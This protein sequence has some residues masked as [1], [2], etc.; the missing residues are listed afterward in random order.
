MTRPE[1]PVG[2]VPD[3][4][5]LDELASALLDGTADDADRALAADPAVAAEVARRQARFERV[6]AVLGEPPAVDPAA[7]EAAIAAALAAADAPEV[8]AARDVPDEL[9]AR[10]SSGG[11]RHTVG[12]RLLG[13]A[14]AVLLAVMLGAVVFGNGSG[15]DSDAASE[16]PTADS[17]EGAESGGD[18]ANFDSDDANTPEVEAGGALMPVLGDLGDFDDVASLLEAATLGESQ[19]E[20]TYTTDAPGDGASRQGACVGDPSVDAEL[21]VLVATATVDGEAVAV[22]TVAGGGTVVVDLASC[23]VLGTSTP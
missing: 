20:E 8:A 13:A 23:T 15:N 11:E 6:R 17:A 7:R 19:V 9:A 22:W 4:D 18:D 16:A 10:R 12:L 2:D 21:E 1:D 5:E 14:A 3:A